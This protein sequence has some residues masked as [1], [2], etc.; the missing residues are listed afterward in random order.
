MMVFRQ[1]FKLDFNDF[2]VTFRH[3][4]AVDLLYG[5]IE[6]HVKNQYRLELCLAVA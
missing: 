2:T 3:M 4:S 6:A 1:M 5:G